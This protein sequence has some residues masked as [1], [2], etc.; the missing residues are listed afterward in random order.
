VVFV[1]VVIALGAFA[2]THVLDR[3]FAKGARS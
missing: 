3:K 2:L 1:V